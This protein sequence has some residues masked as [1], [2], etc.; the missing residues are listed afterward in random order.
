MY[1]YERFKLLN[2]P[3]SSEQKKTGGDYSSDYSRDLYG[4]APLIRTPL[5]PSGVLWL[6]YQGV[7][8]SGVIGKMWVW[9][10]V[11]SNDVM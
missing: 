5:G 7:H 9:L 8:F 2:V 6:D 4:G 11:I 10:N 1:H 3:K